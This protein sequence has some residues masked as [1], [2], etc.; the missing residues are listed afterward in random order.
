MQ[1]EALEDVER[2]FV[3][4]VSLALMALLTSHS[5]PP[6]QSDQQPRAALVTLAV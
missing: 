1:L 4:V 5:L 2:A 3:H 6:H